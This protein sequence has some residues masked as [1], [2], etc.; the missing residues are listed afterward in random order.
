MNGFG[1]IV[2][3]TVAIA[4]FRVAVLNTLSVGVD[5]PPVSNFCRSK[6]KHGPIS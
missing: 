3:R 5:G 1:D 2:K 4:S 6:R